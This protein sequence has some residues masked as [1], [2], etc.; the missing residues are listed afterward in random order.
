LLSITLLI[1][2]KI[3]LANEYWLLGSFVDG[4]GKGV[5]NPSQFLVE[6]ESIHTDE[7]I[8]MLINTAI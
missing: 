3:S 8:Q 4:T 7:E 2:L 6:I 1:N 5:A